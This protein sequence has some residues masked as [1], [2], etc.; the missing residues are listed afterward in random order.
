MIGIASI[1]GAPGV[2]STALAVAAAWPRPVVLV[3][4]DPA[5][6]DLAYRVRPAHGTA[7]AAGQGLVQ[8]AAAVRAGGEPT[9]LEVTGQAQTLACGVSVVQGVSTAAQARGL[10]GLWATIAAACRRADVDVIVDLGRLDRSSAVLPIAAACDVLLPVATA[11]L[12]SVMHLAE[13]I[14]DLSGALVTHRPVTIRPVVVGPDV[15]GVRD[16]GDVDE[17]LD[18]RGMPALPALPVPYDP[19][20]LVRLESGERPTGRRARSS[21]LMRSAAA[22]ADELAGDRVG[23]AA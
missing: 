10:A 4:A 11:T 6:G 21:L 14:G 23:G 7:L 8:L 3:E 12:D 5:G 15:D 22:I 18:Q 20:G 16:C 13:G 2:T 1:K 17:L 9:G 19:R